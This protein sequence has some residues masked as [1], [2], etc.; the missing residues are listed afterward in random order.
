MATLSLC[1]E[2]VLSAF[3]HSFCAFAHDP[4]RRSKAANHSV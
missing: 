3:F 1:G 4:P 2:K